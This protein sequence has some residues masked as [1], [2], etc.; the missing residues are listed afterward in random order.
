M[1]TCWC[2]QEFYIRHYEKNFEMLLWKFY[3]APRDPGRNYSFLF[4]VIISTFSERAE[5][6]LLP[7]PDRGVGHENYSKVS[8]WNVA[9]GNLSW[10]IQS[11]GIIS[12]ISLTFAVTCWQKHSDAKSVTRN[13]LSQATNSKMLNLQKLRHKAEKGWATLLFR[14][15]WLVAFPV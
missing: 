10:S 3:S 2:S 14:A 5:A 11:R 6:I 12:F 8:P 13:D 4:L 7:V 9:H 1:V 15:S